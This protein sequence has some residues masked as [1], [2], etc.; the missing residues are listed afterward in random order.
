[1]VFHLRMGRS[2]LLTIQSLANVFCLLL[3]PAKSCSYSFHAL[4]FK[5]FCKKFLDMPACSETDEKL[6]STRSVALFRSRYY[7]EG[8]SVQVHYQNLIDVVKR[9]RQ[10][11][12]CSGPFGFF[13]IFLH[14]NYISR[15]SKLPVVYQ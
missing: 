14:S 11:V 2:I 4:P 7:S 12:V 1:M 15:F 6:D 5:F 13:K 9:S 3:D 10:F 8:I